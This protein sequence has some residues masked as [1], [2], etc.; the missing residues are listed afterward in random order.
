MLEVDAE[1]FVLRNGIIIFFFFPLCFA[2]SEQ[3]FISYEIQNTFQHYPSLNSSVYKRQIQRYIS[4]FN[5]N[6]LKNS[7]RG[8]IGFLLLITHSTA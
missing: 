6:V 8:K 3:T 1:E 2:K 4:L 7:N 5:K